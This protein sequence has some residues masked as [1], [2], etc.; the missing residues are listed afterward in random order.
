MW[1]NEFN[2]VTARQERLGGAKVFVFEL[3]CGS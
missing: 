1:V 3:Q 2:A